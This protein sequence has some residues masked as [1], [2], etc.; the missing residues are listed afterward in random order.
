MD[1]II[2]DSDPVSM[3]NKKN[4]RENKNAQFVDCPPTL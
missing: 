4:K 1:G 2:S 3:K